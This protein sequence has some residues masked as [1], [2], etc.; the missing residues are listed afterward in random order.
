[1]L[2]GAVPPASG[3]FLQFSMEVPSEMS[4]GFVQDFSFG[5]PDEQGETFIP[6]GGDGMGIFGIR[7]MANQQVL[8]SL[9]TPLGLQA[10][11]PGAQGTIAFNLEAAYANRGSRNTGDADPMPDLRA[12]FRIDRGESDSG[13][14]G[15]PRASLTR[16][17]QAWLFLYGYMC[18]CEIT[19][20]LYG[21]E[22]RIT[23]EYL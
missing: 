10:R 16:F 19:P 23:I 2:L 5:A 7:G 21:G 12:Q 15:A 8:V 3:Q 20:G 9:S 14:A 13:D 17:S 6:L 18:F 22:V 4:A 1:M 11:S